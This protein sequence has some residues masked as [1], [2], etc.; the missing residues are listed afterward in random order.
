MFVAIWWPQ[1]TGLTCNVIQ[2][3][4]ARLLLLVVAYYILDRI[5]F[6]LVPR[7]VFLA[8]LG[9]AK[10]QPAFPETVRRTVSAWFR[11]PKR[12]LTTFSQWFLMLLVLFSST[13]CAQACR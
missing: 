5:S 10:T 1:G 7:G 13:V 2:C 9:L 6:S 12:P 3:R 11:L 4:Y 8:L